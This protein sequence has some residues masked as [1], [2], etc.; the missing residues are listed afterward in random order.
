MTE[1]EKNI[2][3]VQNMFSAYDKGDIKTIINNVADDKVDWKCPVASDISS[4]S[5]A[6]P[7]HNR[8]EVES[9]F[10]ELQENIEPIELKPLRFTAQDDRVIVEGIEHSKIR[11][12]GN[13]YKVDWVMVCV[14]KN[15]K[16]TLLYDYLDTADVI[17]ASQREI[18]KA[19]A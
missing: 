19:A 8:Q 5:W 17:R 7:R 10:K 15:G 14:L 9:F 2:K 1:Q 6:K 11:S 3:I 13:E 16:V 4:I 12:T 18:R